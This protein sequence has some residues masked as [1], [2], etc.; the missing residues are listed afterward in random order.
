MTESKRAFCPVRARPAVPPVSA[1]GV[2]LRLLRPPPAP[3]RGDDLSQVLDVAHLW[4]YAMFFVTQTRC[5]VSAKQLERELG[6]TYK[7]AWRMLNKI[8]NQL[9]DED[10]TASRC[11]RGRG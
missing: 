4:F 11:R 5:G 10:E 3:D 1:A 2:G 7:T 6:V 8:R 9:M